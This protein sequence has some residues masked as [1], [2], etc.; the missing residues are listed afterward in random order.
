MRSLQ[1]CLLL[2]F[3]CAIFLT[4]TS[5]AQN[6]SKWIFENDSDVG[7]IKLPGSVKYDYGLQQ[8]RVTGSGANIWFDHDAFHYVWK[9]IKGDF[10]LTANAAF[11]GKGVEDHR[12][13]GWMVRTPPDSTSNHIKSVVKGDGLTSLQYRR[14]VGNNTDEIKAKLTHADVI[15]LERRGNKY[16]MS[17]ART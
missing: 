7:N 12:K 15:Q 4:Q 2:F 16:I 17:V 11:L 10:I 3:A 14:A 8:F 13:L 1:T 5:S 6:T 9:K